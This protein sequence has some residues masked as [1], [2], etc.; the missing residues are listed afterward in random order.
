MAALL[1]WVAWDINTPHKIDKQESPGYHRGFFYH[2][3]FTHVNRE[4]TILY[5]VY[6]TIVTNQVLF[7]VEIAANLFYGYN[8]YSDL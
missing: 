3:L 5:Q 1:I 4:K 2:N 7:K 6:V 8:G